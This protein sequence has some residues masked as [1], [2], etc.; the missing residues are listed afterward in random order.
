MSEEKS[1]SDQLRQAREERQQTIA[2]MHRLTGVSPNVLQG[3]EEGDFEVVEAVFMRMGLR[4]Y[5]EHLGLDAN[6][7]TQSYDKKFKG[8]PKQPLGKPVQLPPAAASL[9]FSI[10][11]QTG[12]IIGLGAALLIFVAIAV[13]LLGSDEP[14]PD[15]SKKNLRSS[16]SEARKPL[17]KGKTSAPRTALRPLPS[18]RPVPTAQT[19]PANDPLTLPAPAAETSPPETQPTPPSPPQIDPATVVK[20]TTAQHLEATASTA[21]TPTPRPP[22]APPEQSVPPAAAAVQNPATIELSAS[23]SPTGTGGENA[24]Q[25]EI[26]ATPAAAARTPPTPTAPADSLLALRF[27][28]VEEVWVRVWGDGRV[29]FEQTVTAGFTSPNLQARSNFQVT[30]GKPHGLRYWFQ[31]EPLGENGILGTP[32]R[33]LHFKVSKEGVVL[34]GPNSHPPATA[35]DTLP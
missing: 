35:R 20:T 32:N 1:I 11:P 30:S 6:A 18:V 33:V 16:T 31:G 25:T 21:A 14:E 27:E 26:P 34:L 24:A 5:A 19:P 2:D 12:R 9:P 3:L 13:A 8:P 15:A 17:P 7:L 23:E 29:L 10:S 4:T 28:A 22:Q